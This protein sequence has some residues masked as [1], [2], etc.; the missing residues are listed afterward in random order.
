MDGG[1]ARELAPPELYYGR[2]GDRSG[3]TLPFPSTQVSDTASSTTDLWRAVQGRSPR[4]VAAVLNDRVALAVNSLVSA[5][6]RRPLLHGR[7]RLTIDWSRAS[8][9]Q[10]AARRR[11]ETALA[12]VALDD[13]L[14]LPRD[15]LRELLH[16][17]DLYTVTAGASLAP[18][19]K[20]KLRVTKGDLTPLGFEGGQDVDRSTARVYSEKSF[21]VGK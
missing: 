9:W 17:D 6:P 11:F 2:S 8:Q 3:A 1:P 16:S 12:D 18:Y 7:R 10:L 13:D 5:F 14:P 15:A 21:R 20:K 4:E 19:D